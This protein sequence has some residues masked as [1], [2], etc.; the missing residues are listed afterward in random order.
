MSVVKLSTT[1]R[2]T[3]SSLRVTM[4]SPPVFL[5]LPKINLDAPRLLPAWERQAGAS[6]EQAKISFTSTRSFPC[7]S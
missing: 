1:A 7:S 5:T 6:S 4:K 2:L 3:S